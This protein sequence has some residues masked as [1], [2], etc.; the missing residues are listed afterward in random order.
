VNEPHY[1]ISVLCF[2]RRVMTERCL[3]SVIEHS[4]ADTEIIVTD[5]GSVDGTA[6][7]LAGMAEADRRLTIVTNARNEGISGP[8]RRSCER[9]RAP[10]FV[11]IDNDAWVGPGWL[12]ALRAPLDRDPA[13]AEVGRTGQHQSLRDDGIGNPQGPLEYIDG[14]CFMTRTAIAN[15]IGLCDRFF[16]FAY[17]DDSDYSLRLRARGW[18]IATADGIPVWHPN[19]PDKDHHGGIDLGPHLHLAQQR[20]VAR[21]SDYLRRRAFDPTV[22]IRRSAAIGDVVIATSLPKLV[23]G[24]I[25]E[26][27]IFFATILPELVRGNPHVEDVVHSVDFQSMGRR[28]AYAWD[29][30]GLYERRLG[31][32]YWKSFAEATMFAP[33]DPTPAGDLH[34][35]PAAEAEADKLVGRPERLAIVAP[36]ATGWAGKDIGPDAWTG[37]I[38]ELGRR[39]YVVAEVGSGRQLTDADLPLGGR[40]SL[41]GLAAILGRA[42]LFMGLDSGPYHIA[43]AMGCPSVVFFGCTR[44]DIVSDGDANV[45]A[46]TAPDLDC[47][48]CHHIQGPGT[49]SFQGC[50]RGDLACLGLRPT[51]ILDAV[52][53]RVEMN[54]G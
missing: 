26:A 9:A 33:E 38:D 1:T 19:E 13:V 18:K 4:P 46:V 24:L 50:A 42:K 32:P 11:S 54:G 43:R 34:P 7:L 53:Q 29:L 27:R 30:D 44:Q 31:R 14:S 51:A 20:F 35:G 47:L 52:I 39:G 21:W 8:K 36:Q 25:P 5:N 10:Y 49:T 15:E 37:A 3:R 40:T 28:M 6:E 41:M 2:N 48:G 45:T 22:L 23:K 12:N 17:G 16:P